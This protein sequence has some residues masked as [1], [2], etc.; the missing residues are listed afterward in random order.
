[1]LK[2]RW[3]YAWIFITFTA[4]FTATLQTIRLQRV[5]QQ[6]KTLR[7]SVSI[8][9]KD[10]RIRFDLSDTDVAQILEHSEGED[11]KSTRLN[12]SHT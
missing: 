8:P 7:Q 6:I 2:Q 3:K 1:M 10:N 9:D 5:S 11:R 4:I 12:S